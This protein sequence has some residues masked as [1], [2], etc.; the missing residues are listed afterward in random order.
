MTYHQGT[1]NEGDINANPL[2]QSVTH[3]TA[4]PSGGW[5]VWDGELHAGS[6]SVT[7]PSLHPWQH[8]WAPTPTL[9]ADETA[10]K[11]LP[12]PPLYPAVL[13]LSPRRQLPLS[14]SQK[15]QEGNSFM[16]R[17]AGLSEDFPRL[18]LFHAHGDLVLVAL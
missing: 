18:T 8:V 9:P 16:K 14:L 7:G 6:L 10:C 4:L 5:S 11:A 2:P 1:S 15:L 17:Q 12:T 3:R 13:F